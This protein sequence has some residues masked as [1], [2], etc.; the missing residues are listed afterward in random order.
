[1][2]ATREVLDP[3]GRPGRRS[4]LAGLRSAV[5]RWGS[6]EEM[7]AE[8]AQVES[9]REGGSPCALLGDRHRVLVCGTLRS[10][11]LRPR[12]GTPALEA[13]VF[14]GSGS[15]AV[16]WLG[17]REIAGVEAGR[18]IKVEGLVSVVDRH[19]VMYNPRY[20]LLPTAVAPA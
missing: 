8:E 3:Q 6:R 12:A 15:L 1:M 17:R 18:R 11:T 20:E 4:G 5:S 14:D 13:E 16:I 9:A 19:A 10:V 2:G 7:Q